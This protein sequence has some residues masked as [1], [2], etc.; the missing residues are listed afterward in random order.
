MKKL[1]TVVKNQKGMTLIELLAVVVILAIIAAVAVPSVGK[2]IDNSRADSNRSN[3]LLIINAAKLAIADDENSTVSSKIKSSNG[4]TLQDLVDA[5]Y[6]DAIP[7]DPY[8]KSKTYA[9]GSY[10]KK[11]D[12]GYYIQL[13]TSKGTFKG[14][15]KDIN[16]GNF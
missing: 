3:A 5:G 15:E 7:K 4:A 11:D 8:D 1:Q 13:V 14:S 10:V 9:S 12:T 16:S 6:L 2:I